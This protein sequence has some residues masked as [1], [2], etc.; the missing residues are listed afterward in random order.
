MI[1]IHV[2][3]FNVTCSLLWQDSSFIIINYYLYMYSIIHLLVF[4]INHSMKNRLQIINIVGQFYIRRNRGVI[5]RKKRLTKWQKNLKL[6]NLKRKHQPSPANC[7]LGDL[8]VYILGRFTIFLT[9]F[10]DVVYVIYFNTR[11]IIWY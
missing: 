8:L 3:I 7:Y 10:R 1:E 9:L 11:F 5:S 2:S 4:K 6:L